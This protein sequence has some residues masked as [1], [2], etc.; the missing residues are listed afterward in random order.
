[1]ITLRWTCCHYV[2]LIDVN[3]EAELSNL[4]KNQQGALAWKRQKCVPRALAFRLGAPLTAS[5]GLPPSSMEMLW[6]WCWM[7]VPEAM[8]RKPEDIHDLVLLMFSQHLWPTVR[9]MGFLSKIH[10]WNVIDL[11]SPSYSWE[12]SS[13]A[14]NNGVPLSQ[15]DEAGI[16][17]LMFRWGNWGLMLT[18]LSESQ[19]W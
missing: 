8:P 12:F 5:H 18:N 1:M 13:Q 14:W 10:F 15:L 2:H 4:H 7:R 6:G 19:K 17:I 9:M 11:N 16:I 3:T